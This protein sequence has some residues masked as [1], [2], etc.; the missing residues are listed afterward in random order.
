M[1]QLQQK[2]YKIAIENY[3]FWNMEPEKWYLNWCVEILDGCN[4]PSIVYLS[5]AIYL[6]NCLALSTFI[7]VIIS[8]YML[9]LAGM[10]ILICIVLCT[11]WRYLLP[12]KNKRQDFWKCIVYVET[13]LFLNTILVNVTDWCL[14]SCG[15]VLI[16]RFTAW[17]GILSYKWNQKWSNDERP[18]H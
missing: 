16:W 13:N 2:Q 8:D 11:T 18:S 5:D 14:G 15:C 9:K 12:H 7:V 17:G 6:L 10:L 3:P 4:I 1:K